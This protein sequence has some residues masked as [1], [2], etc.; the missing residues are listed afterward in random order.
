ME[1]IPAES[2]QNNLLFMPIWVKMD[3]RFYKNTDFINLAA[4]C[5]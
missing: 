2:E 3:D 4:K 1:P 5:E